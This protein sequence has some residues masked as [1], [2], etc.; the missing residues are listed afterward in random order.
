MLYNFSI[1]MFTVHR[2]ESYSAGLTDS[3]AKDVVGTHRNA[4][5]LHLAILTTSLI[6]QDVTSQSHRRR[7][8]TRAIPSFVARRF[9]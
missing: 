6:Y 5:T 8:Q 3:T 2:G 7:R 4:T 1:Y 9:E